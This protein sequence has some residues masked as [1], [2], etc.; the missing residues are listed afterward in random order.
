[1]FAGGYL[2][3]L[4]IKSAMAIAFKI[5]VLYLVAE[6]LAD[7]FVIFRALTTTGAVTSCAL[8]PFFYGADDLLV[9]V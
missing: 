3:F 1:M 7:A 4:V 5:L 9:L 8:K 2:F 6:F